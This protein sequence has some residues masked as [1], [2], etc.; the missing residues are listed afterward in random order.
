MTLLAQCSMPGEWSKALGTSIFKQSDLCSHAEEA[1]EM[2]S[3]YIKTVASGSLSQTQQTV[4]LEACHAFESCREEFPGCYFKN[5]PTL[6][7]TSPSTPE[8]VLCCQVHTP[9]YLPC[10]HEVIG[11]GSEESGN[12]GCMFHL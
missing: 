12:C 3:C 4:P 5:L 7:T 8:S 2:V 6:C 1:L 10:Q 11:T 9:P